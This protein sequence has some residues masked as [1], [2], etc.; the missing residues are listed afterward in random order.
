MEPN[1]NNNIIMGIKKKNNNNPPWVFLIQAEDNQTFEIICYMQ[2]NKSYANYVH[3]K[4]ASTQPR[5][6]ISL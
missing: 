5:T 2:W 4:Q 6:I 1:R 3:Y